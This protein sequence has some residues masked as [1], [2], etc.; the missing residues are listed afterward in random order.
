MFSK[1]LIFLVIFLVISFKSFL[2]SANR[3]SGRG[4]IQNNN[5][6]NADQKGRDGKC[7]KKKL[8]KKKHIFI[9]KNNF[10]LFFSLVFSLFNIVTFK[11]D[12]CVTNSGTTGTTG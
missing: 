4:G 11:N 7:N 6:K 3:N 2:A 12:A 8:K 5:E 9:P 10:S 1:Q